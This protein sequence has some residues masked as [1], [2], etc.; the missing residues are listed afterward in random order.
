MAPVSMS[1]ITAEC[2]RSLYKQRERALG[3]GLTMRPVQRLVPRRRG[4]PRAGPLRD[5]VPGPGLERADVR[6][7]RALLG[8]VLVA[9]DA[10]HGGQHDGPLGAVGRRQ[11]RS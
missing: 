3:G 10:H 5:A 7:L 6:L 11:C 2:A 8:D 1:A 9:C 4:Q